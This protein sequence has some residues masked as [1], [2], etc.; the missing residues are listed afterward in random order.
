MPFHLVSLP[1]F[2]DV[3]FMWNVLPLALAVPVKLLFI[4]EYPTQKK[5]SLVTLLIPRLVKVSCLGTFMVHSFG[6]NQNLA[7]YCFISSIFLLLIS[8]ILKVL[9]LAYPCLLCKTY[10]V[11]LHVLDVCDISVESTFP[12][13]SSSSTISRILFFLPSDWMS[14]GYLLLSCHGLSFSQW[15]IAESLPWVPHLSMFG[16]VG[17]MAFSCQALGAHQNPT[18]TI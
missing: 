4:L 13:A 17:S 12:P 2:F 1:W 14:S 10:N 15:L 11:I 5:L 7:V 3:T 18:A 16:F 6:L 8:N 9:M